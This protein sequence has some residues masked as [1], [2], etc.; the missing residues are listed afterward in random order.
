[1]G[2]FQSTLTQMMVMF[3][4]IIAGF[5]LQ[6]KNLLP[7]VAATVLSKLENY[8]FVP[9]LVLDTFMTYC[10]I[11]ALLEQYKLILYCLLLLL[12]S[13][14]ISFPL[15]KVL[16]PAR[17]FSSDDRRYGMNVYKY[18]LTFANFAFMGNAMALGVLGDEGLFKYLLFTLP[19]NLAVYT[20][21]IIIL[22]PKGSRN[23][24]ALSNLFNPIFVSLVAGMVFGILGIG[25][26]L[27]DF[28]LMAV[29]S[30]KS[31]MAPVAMLLTGLVIGRYNVLKLVSN[32][33]VYIATA[34][35][36]IIIPSLMLT[37]LKII[38]AGDYVMTLTV[39]AFATPLGLNTVV[40]PSAY[41]ENPETGASMAM[42]SHT[43][44]V[45]TIP[46][47]Y[48]LFVVLW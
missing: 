17:R 47:I 33:R 24:N 35:R 44:A 37:L 16:V 21:G 32:K 13:F 29:S 11:S 18:A 22:I 9:A 27:P 2:V 15:S 12:L 28:A 38:G 42:I 40:F 34:F 14:C 48:L 31:C 6:K 1:M 19:L 23:K 10:R 30:A 20:W 39:F 41:G 43:L 26:Y 7:A 45:V 25:N 3:S 5:V 4:F 8:V 46:L 36:L